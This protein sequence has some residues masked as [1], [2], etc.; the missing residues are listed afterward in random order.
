MGLSALLPALSRDFSVI[1]GNAEL[2]DYDLFERLRNHPQLSEIDLYE[3]VAPLLHQRLISAADVVLNVQLVAQWHTKLSDRRSILPLYEDDGELALAVANPFD[4]DIAV[5]ESE[6]P[7]KRVVVFLMRLSEIKNLWSQCELE[8]SVDGVWKWIDEA[9]QMGASDVHFFKHEDGYQIKFRVHGAMQLRHEVSV[10]E[11]IKIV[12]QVKAL[13]GLDLAVIAGPQDGRISN[14]R[15]GKLV[16][17][18]VATLP[19]IHGEDMVLRLFGDDNGLKTLAQLRISD[20]VYRAIC[21]TLNRRTGLILVTGATGSGK[22]TTLY[23]MLRHLLNERNLNIVSLEDPV[24]KVILGVRQSPINSR[25][26][27]GFSDA[28]RAVLRQDPDVILVGEIRDSETARL[29]IEA[30][31]T[32]HLVLASLHTGNYADTVQRLATFGIDTYLIEHCIAG[33]YCQQLVPIACR[34][35]DGGGCADCHFLGQVGRRPVF[36][37]RVGQGEIVCEA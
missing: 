25:I 33:V 10:K 3:R 21:T 23:A 18:R 26:G 17:A 34:E 1:F 36:S 20:A 6:R 16:Q 29:T 2:P 8:E 15:Q 19:T 11:G 5:C 27:Y 37:Y 7:E 13:A 31:Y 22:T 28:L 35:C 4:P 24:E 14:H 9:S 12:N 30:A 32:G